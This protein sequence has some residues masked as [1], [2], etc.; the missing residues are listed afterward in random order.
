[1]IIVSVLAYLIWRIRCEWRIEQEEDQDKLQWLVLINT[2]LK[3]D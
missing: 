1:M 3:L 2:R